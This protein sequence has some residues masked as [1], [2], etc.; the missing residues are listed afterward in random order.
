MK[1]TMMNILLVAGIAMAVNAEGSFAQKT[2]FEIKPDNTAIDWTGKKVTGEHKG[3]IQLKKGRV[4][5][6]GG[7][8]TG[9][10]FEIDMSSIVNTDMEGEW[11]TKLE[12]HLKSDDFFSTQKFPVATLEITKAE[13]IKERTYNITGKLTIKGITHE[14]SFPATIEI[15]KNKF[16]AAADITIDR[17]LWDIRYG[18]KKFYED[19]GDKMIYD[20]F[21]IKVKTGATK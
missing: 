21:Y 14:I 8:L 3:T 10:V 1:K 7:K 20:D 9:G 17:T 11:K 12:N 5:T 18:S 6:A 16:A 19:I 4:E 13:L 2:T 15:D